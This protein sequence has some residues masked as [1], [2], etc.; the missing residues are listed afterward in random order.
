MRYTGAA[1][2]AELRFSAHAFTIVAVLAGLLALWGWAAMHSGA[3][4]GFHLGVA[5]WCALEARRDL[6]L[7]NTITGEQRHG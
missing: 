2:A 7:A 1:R 3:V 6:A 4:T 5:G